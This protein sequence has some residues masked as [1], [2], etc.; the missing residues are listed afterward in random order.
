MSDLYSIQATLIN[1]E[2]ISLKNFQGKKILLVNTASECYFTPQYIE[3]QALY[4]QFE[5]LGFVVLAFPSNDFGGQEP[6][7]NKQISNFCKSMFGVTFPMFEKVKVIG[8][9][10]HPIFDY[11]CHKSKNQTMD[12]LIEWNFTK[13]LINEK[14]IL[15]QVYPSAVNPLD[16]EI[17]QWIKEG[18]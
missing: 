16:E 8:E 15:Q 4:E 11:L 2:K 14:G 6:G 1:G 10:Q 9:E 5:Y 12:V 18:K 3:L 17:T 7:D 13:F